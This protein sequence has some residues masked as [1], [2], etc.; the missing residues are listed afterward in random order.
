MTMTAPMVEQRPERCRVARSGPPPL[1]TRLEGF[2]ATGRSTP[3]LVVDLDVVG[4]RYDALRAGAPD[5]DVFYAVK[6]LDGSPVIDLLRDRGSGFD[7]AS[8]GEIDRCLA[9]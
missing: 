7:V 4:A 2:L 9:A 6:A 3:Y 1:S 5:I 8:R